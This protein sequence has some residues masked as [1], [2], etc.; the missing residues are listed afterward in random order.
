MNRFAKSRNY[1]FFFLL[2]LALGAVTL[3]GSIKAEAPKS[4]V[5]KSLKALRR[6]ATTAKERRAYEA[7]E[8]R[9]VEITP[10]TEDSVPPNQDNA[11]LLYYQA[12]LLRPEP[13]EA[14]KYEMHSI[15][16][17]TRQIRTYLGHCLPRACCVEFKFNIYN[18]I[19]VT[20]SITSEREL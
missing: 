18:V 3:L 10:W 8:K 19:H 1:V 14:I 16:E 7:Y 12:F 2:L 5:E 9:N 6:A 17:P 15:S 4:H 13:P 11:A 20:Y